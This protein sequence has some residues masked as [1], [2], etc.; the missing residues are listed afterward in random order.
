MCSHSVR[1]LFTQNCMLRC[2]G[3]LIPCDPT[4]QI[5]LFLPQLA[6]PFSW[7][8]SSFFVNEFSV[9]MSE[10]SDGAYM[11]T[12]L[13]PLSYSISLH[14]YSSVML[15]SYFC[16][17]DLRVQSEISYHG[18]SNFAYFAQD[19]LAIVLTFLSPY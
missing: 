6:E 1:C 11:S 14:L 4:C 17:Y 16:Y 7:R 13:S 15:P 10:S 3:V 19:S 2:V 8:T 12:L 18:F 5:L 9:S